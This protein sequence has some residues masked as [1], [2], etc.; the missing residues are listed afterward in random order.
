MRREAKASL[1]VYLYELHEEST[2]KK[3]KEWVEWSIL[4]A[5]KEKLLPQYTRVHEMNGIGNENLRS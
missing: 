4:V 2:E 1:F 5:E 3:E